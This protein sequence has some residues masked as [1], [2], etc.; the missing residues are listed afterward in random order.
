MLDGAFRGDSKTP[1][2]DRG[3]FFM[4]GYAAIFAG[5]GVMAIMRLIYWLV[6]ELTGDTRKVSFGGRIWLASVA[7]SATPRSPMT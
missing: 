4:D 6:I 1:S 3:R 2:I 5:V 7:A